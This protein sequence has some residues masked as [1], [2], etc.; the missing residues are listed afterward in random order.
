MIDIDT[1]SERVVEIQDKIAT[2]LE[3]VES[4]KGASPALKAVVRE[5]NAQCEGMMDHIDEA[6]EEPVR[7]HVIELEQAADS[8]KVAAEAEQ[9]LKG[10]TRGAIIDAHEA[11]SA[12]KADTAEQL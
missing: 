12:L 2:A 1:I 4:D 11:I 7:E 8:A 10:S 6:A 5:L 9:N 3:E